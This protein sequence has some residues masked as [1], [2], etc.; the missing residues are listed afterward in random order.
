MATPNLFIPYLKH[1]EFTEL[2]AKIFKESGVDACWAER[3]LGCENAVVILAR[4]EAAEDFSW[5][6][7]LSDKSGGFCVLRL[8]ENVVPIVFY[9]GHRLEGAPGDTWESYFEQLCGVTWAEDMADFNGVPCFLAEMPS[10][11]PEGVWTRVA[12]TFA[13]G[14]AFARA[15]AQAKAGGLSI[16][17]WRWFEQRTPLADLPLVIMEKLGPCDVALVNFFAKQ[18]DAYAAAVSLLPGEKVAWWWFDPVH[19]VESGEGS[20]AADFISAW[21]HVAIIVG[22]AAGVIRWP[23]KESGVL[24]AFESSC[25]TVHLG[26][27]NG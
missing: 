15:G 10:P 27:I 24:L 23:Q 5:M 21:Y 25:H 14:D 16:Q 18:L 13:S 19:D 4:V 8:D 6:Q 7:A 9:C 26:T 11:K 3:S 20:G 1:N 22:E 2:T 17:G 12:F